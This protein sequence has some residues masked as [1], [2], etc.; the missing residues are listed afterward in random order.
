MIKAYIHDGSIYME[1]HFLAESEIKEYMAGWQKAVF[2]E[3]KRIGADH[4]IY[5]TQTYWRD[6]LVRID[7]YQVPLDD[8]EFNKRVS[9]LLEKEDAIIKAWHKGTAY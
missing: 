8:R 2:P 3:A 9:N 1:P 7:L 4:F 6:E 5:A